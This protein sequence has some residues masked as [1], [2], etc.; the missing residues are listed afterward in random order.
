MFTGNKTC[1]KKSPPVV[2]HSTDQSNI[3]S[4]PSGD[5]DT[6]QPNFWNM[7]PRPGS[8]SHASTTRRR[9]PWT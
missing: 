9:V 3:W 1:Q 2:A 5:Y 6:G 4:M 7:P 8:T